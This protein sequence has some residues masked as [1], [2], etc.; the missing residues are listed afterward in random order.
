MKRCCD[1]RGLEFLEVEGRK[2]GIFGLKEAIAAVQALGLSDEKRI[3]E[4]L[5]A[6]IAAQNY[7][8]PEARE[9][10]RN[11]LLRE[12]KKAVKRDG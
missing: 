5:L 8:P 9:A 12:Y 3:G 1:L 11:A 10:Y 4:E 2:I 7:V 6:R